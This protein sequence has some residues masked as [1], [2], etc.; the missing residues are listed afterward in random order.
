MKPT[1]FLAAATLGLLLATPARAADEHAAHHAPPAATDAAA[2]WTEG[3][4]RKI[5]RAQAKLTL[6]HGRIENLDMDGMTMV[7]KVADPRL[8]EGLKTGDKIRFAAESR[9]GVLT[10]TAVEPA[11]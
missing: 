2:P 4:V 7:F 11:N 1:H 5:D 10:V 6:R 8:L 9:Q 3:E